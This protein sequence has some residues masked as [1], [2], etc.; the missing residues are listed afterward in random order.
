MREGDSFERV[1]VALGARAYDIL[2]G[3]DLLDGAG[4]RIAAIAPGGTCAIVTD[5]QVAPLYLARLRASLEAAGL[6]HAAIVVPPGEGS[7]SFPTYAEV[8]GKALEA[9]SSAATWWWRWAAGSSE[10]LRDSSRR[11]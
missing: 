8:C 11:R 5:G 2:I 7:K 1:A 9:G 4:R 3:P 10:P 6:R